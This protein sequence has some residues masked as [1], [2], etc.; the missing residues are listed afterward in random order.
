MVREVFDDR[1]A[2]DFGANLE[3]PLHALEGLKRGLNCFFA[4]ALPKSQGRRRRCVERVVFAGHVHFEFGPQRAA[5]AEF[6]SREPVFVAQ[7]F[8]L[9]ICT[10]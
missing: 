6:P 9:P 4:H 2:R 10:F 1:D 3:P 7:V 5:A 8:D